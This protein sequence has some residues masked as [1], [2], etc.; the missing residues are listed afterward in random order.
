MKPCPICGHDQ[1]TALGRFVVCAHCAYI[2]EGDATSSARIDIADTRHVLDD[3]ANRG[4][5]A[6]DTHDVAWLIGVFARALDELECAR[7][8]LEQ[9]VG[10]AE[11]AHED[12]RELAREDRAEEQRRHPLYPERAHPITHIRED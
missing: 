11:L 5:P 6:W 8:D 4:A 9:A 10:M 3:L 12:C 1:R 2:L 7:G